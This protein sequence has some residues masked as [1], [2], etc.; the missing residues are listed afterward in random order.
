M[1]K[2]SD[3]VSIGRTLLQH[4][5]NKQ[6]NLSLFEKERLNNLKTR[7]NIKFNRDSCPEVFNKLSINWDGLVT[8][9]C[10]DYDN[11]MI[12]GNIKNNTLGDIFHSDKINYYRNMIL[13]NKHSELDL[14]RICNL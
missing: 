6:T 10:G 7:E 8:A 5:N 14:C 9:C 2:I 13:S 12:V 4:I 1:Q 11:M 3:K